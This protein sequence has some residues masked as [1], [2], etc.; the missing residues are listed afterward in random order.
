MI[1]YRRLLLFSVLTILFLSP[2]AIAMS[3]GWSNFDSNKNY[4]QSAP[5]NLSS[6]QLA[7]SKSVD[8]SSFK[9][10][11]ASTNNTFGCNET[12]RVQYGNDG[13]SWTS[14][15]WS[16]WGATEDSITNGNIDLSSID[17][18]KYVRPQF[19]CVIGK[20]ETGGTDYKYGNCSISTIKIYYENYMS[21]M[22]D[23]LPSVGS[24]VGDFLTNLA[25]GVGAFIII[26][27][28][29]SGV[30]AIIYAIVVVV[31]G[32]AGGGNSV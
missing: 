4:T 21:D 22:M 12:F 10:V 20:N 17:N 19:A 11:D 9:W 3:T 8:L 23:G 5:Y 27:G 6:K 25:P 1:N 15:S 24:D 2:I 29:F 26:I 30:A 16:S 13:S 7:I 28:V 31:K 14:G 18:V 32:K